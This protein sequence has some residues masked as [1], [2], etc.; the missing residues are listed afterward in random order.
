MTTQVHDITTAKKSWKDR[1]P[2]KKQAAKAVALTVFGAAV[3]LVA[4]DKV[5][6]PN[7]DSDSEENETA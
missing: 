5:V 1:L 3:A 4:Y 7:H 6:N 2:T